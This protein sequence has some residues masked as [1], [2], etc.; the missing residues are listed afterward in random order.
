[1]VVD[2]GEGDD[3]Q[4][5]VELAVAASIQ[6]VPPLLPAGGVD[7]AG[8]GECGEGRLARHPAGVAAGNEKLRATDRPDAA[9]LE[10]LGRELAEE[11]GESML[12]LGDLSGSEGRREGSRTLGVSPP[13]VARAP[14]PFWGWSA[15]HPQ[16]PGAT[17]GYARGSA[18]ARWPETRFWSG[19]GDAALLNRTQEVAGSSPASSMKVLL[20][21]GEGA[22]GVVDASSARA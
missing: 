14:P 21:A 16:N 3:V 6:A 11:R 2:A 15:P 20:G 5:P 9:L 17:A 12:G 10:Q 1:V 22:G 13:S 19:F 7:R 8:A 18:P 4:R